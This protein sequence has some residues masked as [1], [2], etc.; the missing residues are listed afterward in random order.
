MGS[1]FESHFIGADWEGKADWLFSYPTTH[2]LTLPHV[3][4]TKR[5]EEEYYDFP[6]SSIV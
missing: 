3:P 1:G 2:A 5:R 4:Y 6:L